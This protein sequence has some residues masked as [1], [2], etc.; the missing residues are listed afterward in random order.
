VIP[1]SAGKFG[2]GPAAVIPTPPFFKR[3]R[4]ALTKKPLPFDKFRV[5]R[6]VKVGR[7]RKPGLDILH[8]EVF[9]DET[10]KGACG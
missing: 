2:D 10:V 6:R 3:R 8:S 7:V 5:G 9:E 1:A 4:K